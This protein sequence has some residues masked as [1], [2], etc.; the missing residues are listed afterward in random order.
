MADHIP[1]DVI[2]KI[3]QRLPVKSLIHFTSVSKRWRLIILQDPH[4]AASHYQIASHN[5][6]LR[7][8]VCFRIHLDSDGFFESQMTLS[9]FPIVKRD[10]RCPFKKPHSMAYVYCSCRGLVYAGVNGKQKIEMYV[11]NP[12]TGLSQKLSDPGVIDEYQ[13]F[14]GFGYVLAT[15]DYKILIANS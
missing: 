8:S 11:W 1:E 7:H 6:T 2:A 13:I 9:S 4:F 12:S 5:K 14:T 3:F 15:H 10:L